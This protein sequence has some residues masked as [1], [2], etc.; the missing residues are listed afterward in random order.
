MHG[1]SQLGSTIESD[2][3]SAQ[4]P[5]DDGHDEQFLTSIGCSM[6]AI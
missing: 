1:A 6:S 2:G 3:I 4:R 5:G